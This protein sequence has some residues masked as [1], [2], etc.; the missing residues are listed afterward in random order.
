LLKA[1]TEPDATKQAL[2]EI[3]GS[4]SGL[5]AAQQQA[6]AASRAQ[7]ASTAS[8][9]L[10]G[11]L[12]LGLGALGAAAAAAP[13]PETKMQ[14][15][16]VGSAPTAKFEGPLEQ[17]LKMSQSGYTQ[18]AQPEKAEEQGMNYYSYGQPSDINL[19]GGEEQ[20]FAA[21][22]IITPLMAVGGHAP[23]G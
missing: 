13:T 18:P 6:N 8:Q 14:R 7:A 15:F 5:S 23:E 19:G 10:L 4:I 9:S 17:F 21:G 11:S 22:G 20:Q 16:V 12:G 3:R 2:A 1:K